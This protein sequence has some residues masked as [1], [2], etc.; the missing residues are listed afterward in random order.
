MTSVGETKH[1]EVKGNIN[2]YCEQWDENDK[3]DDA[4]K[5]REESRLANTSASGSK[6]MIKNFYAVVTK[7]YESGWGDM[8]HFGG[9]RTID[10]SH[11]SSQRLHEIYLGHKMNIKRGDRVA[12]LGCGVAGPARNFARFFECHVTGVTISE[13]QVARA[14]ELNKKLDCTKCVKVVQGD[15]MKTP[16][17]DNSLDGVYAIEATCHTLD[18]LAVFGE[19]YRVL[20]PGA[21]F[22]CYEWVTTPLF[23]ENNAEHQ[24]IVAGI[25]RTNGLP[26]NVPHHV[27]DDSLKEVGFELV[28]SCDLAEKSPVPWYE[29]LEAKFSIS[30]FRHTGLGRLFTTLTVGGLEKI[31]LAPPGSLKVLQVLNEAA[32]FLC[33]G[34]KQGI[35]TVEYF[36]LAR[37]PE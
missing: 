33:A 25:N 30:G 32:E 8:F 3:G 1:S 22:A 15:F 23:D 24:K 7:F 4:E 5:K 17:K 12:D 11:E 26:G 20:K 34:G 16:F 10:M 35:Y 28:E 37:K 6:K 27:I 31:G 36:V 13:H 18:K 19:A 9:R 21:Y 29:P 2:E 14:I